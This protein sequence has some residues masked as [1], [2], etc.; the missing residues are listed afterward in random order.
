MELKE[1]E[2]V[3]IISTKKQK[4]EKNKWELGGSGWQKTWWKAGSQRNVGAGGLKWEPKEMEEVKIISK[5]IGNQKNLNGNWVVVVG[6]RLGGSL[7]VKGMREARW[8][9]CEPKETEEVK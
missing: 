8:A 7:E 9:Q 6:Q 4:P 1:M 5:K 2:E 3:K